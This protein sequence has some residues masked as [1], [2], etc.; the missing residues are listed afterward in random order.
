[1]FWEDSRIRMTEAVFAE[2]MVAPDEGFDAMAQEN[3][4]PT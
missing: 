4:I 3:V 1:M 2:T